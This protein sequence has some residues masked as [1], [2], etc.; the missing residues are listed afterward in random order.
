MPHPTVAR[1]RRTFEGGGTRDL[2]WRRAQLDGLLRMFA[3]HEVEF[4]DALAADL[5]RPR[6][7]GWLADVQA[8]V[9]EVK[10]LRR[11]LARWTAE[12][13]VRPPWQLLAAKPR[14]MREPLGVVLIIAPWN[15]PVHLLVTPL[16]AALAAGNAAVVKPSELA[17]AVSAVLAE[18]L[19][20]YL[21]AEA[22]AV[23][24]GGVAE[25]STLLQERFDHIFYTG[26]GRVGRI[27][28][29]AAARH[30]TPV[31][32]ELGGKCPVIVDAGANLRVAARRV[33]WGKF[34]NAGQTCVAPD[35]VLVAESVHDELVD[36]MVRAVQAHRGADPRHSESFGRIVNESHARRLQA[37]LDQGGYGTIAFGGTVDVAARYVAPTI[38]AKVERHAAVM[39]EEIFGPILPVV[40]VDDTE[41]AIRH[42]NAGEKPLALYVFASSDAV[43][44]RVLQTTSSGG[45]CVN[46]VM[47]HLLVPG[48]PFGGV[49]AS[50]YGDYHGRWGV[51]TFSHRRSVLERPT[52]FEMPVLYPPYSAAKERI[53]RRLF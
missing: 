43:V 14:I 47:T 16:A 35:Y 38:L 5:G 53:V 17:P 33:V 6:F 8:T 26:N 2:G 12:R 49:G 15:Y 22:V 36:E 28:A 30:L 1:L 40:P 21:D 19:P 48:L 45:A 20:A 44:K 34:I 25:T 32:L 37:L 42:V 24:E 10:E 4:L 50:G 27:V 13:R 29:E 18:L 51:E 9:R 23:V 52:W 11:N 41:E 39:G 31:T 3:D 46:D 7:E